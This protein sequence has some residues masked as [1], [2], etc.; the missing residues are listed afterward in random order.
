MDHKSVVGGRSPRLQ[1]GGALGESFKPGNIKTIFKKNT[2]SSQL[3]AEEYQV[4]HPIGE[5]TWLDND[6]IMAGQRPCT[7]VLEQL[8]NLDPPVAQGLR[9]PDSTY[10]RF[11]S[12]HTLRPLSCGVRAGAMAFNPDP[13]LSL[14]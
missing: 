8:W 10:F 7:L 9:S 2:Q 1:W 13:E 11:Q 5:R 14:E 4:P 12:I 6:W 3:G